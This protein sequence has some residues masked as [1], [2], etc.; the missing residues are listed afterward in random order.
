M[1]SRWENQK[2]VV[3]FY[4]QAGHSIRE[5][6]KEFSIPKSTLSGWFKNVKL[7]DTKKKILKN[8]QKQSLVIARQ[9]A[10]IWHNQEKTKRIETAEKEAELS[11]K[12]ID[13]RD[14][15]VLELALAMLYLG[16]GAKNDRMSLGN[17][18]PEILNFFAN[19]VDKLYGIE[20]KRIK[21][22]LHLRADQQPN[23]LRKYWSSE[24]KIPIENFLSVS[25]GKRTRGKKTHSHYKGVCVL[26]CANIAIQRKLVYLGKKYCAKQ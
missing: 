3:L 17:S 1:K 19:C 13:C 25:I 9:K 26:N 5:A 21:C 4:R 15:N 10:V 14:R 20:R 2:S 22:E 24:L 16:E 12:K 23:E 11:L 8:K 7:D 6:E 18:N